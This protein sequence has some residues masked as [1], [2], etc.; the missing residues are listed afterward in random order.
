MKERMPSNRSPIR[1]R[2]RP[3]WRGRKEEDRSRCEELQALARSF[4]FSPKEAL[5]KYL[6]RRDRGLL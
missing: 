4:R 1:L 3:A 5:S 2:E 6:T